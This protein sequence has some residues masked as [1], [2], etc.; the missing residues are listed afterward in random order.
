LKVVPIL[1]DHSPGITVIPVFTVD[2]T[3]VPEAVDRH[4]EDV[5]VEVVSGSVCTPVETVV[6]TTVEVTVVN[7][8]RVGVGVHVAMKARSAV[9][10]ASEVVIRVG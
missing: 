3:Q 1:P 2:E 9:S 5:K 8:V 4:E 7:K 10:W 6:M